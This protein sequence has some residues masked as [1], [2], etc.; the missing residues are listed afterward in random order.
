[1]KADNRI[2]LMKM[3]VWDVVMQIGAI[4]S[5]IR[6]QIGRELTKDEWNKV[7]KALEE[8]VYTIRTGEE[9]EDSHYKSAMF[10]LQQPKT[11]PE[12]EAS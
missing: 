9:V 8:L 4:S 12:N 3:G 11:E 2:A 7:G 1:M 10:L 6:L 5:S